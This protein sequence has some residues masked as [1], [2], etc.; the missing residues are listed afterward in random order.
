ML[1]KNKIISL[2]FLVLLGVL[3]LY[4]Y[5]H[6][7][8]IRL[9]NIREDLPYHAEWQVKSLTEEKQNEV[10]LILN[11]PF[12]YQSEGGQS[13]VFSSADNQYV[14][15]LFKYKR[16][17]PAWFV[18]LMPDSAAFQDF[19]ENHVNKRAAKLDRVF[20][21]HKVAYDF[22]QNESGLIFVQLNPSHLSKKITLTDKVGLSHQIDL[23][24]AAFV[25]Q[26]KG[27]MLRHYFAK[28]LNKAQTQV[29]KERI[30]QIFATYVSEYERG[31]YDADHGVMQNFGFIGDQPFH[32]DLGKFKIDNHYK[33]PEVY[34]A[35]LS[36]VA[37]RMR[38]W[39]KKYYPAYY[40]EMRQH[41]ESELSQIFH[42][43]FTFATHEN[44]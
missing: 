36:K 12:T 1:F 38:L 35:D 5:E 27:E 20:M 33:Q 25:V 14:L 44:D 24:E 39:M 13:Y 29:V 4:V 28:L 7:F 43:P 42:K 37:E 40:D 15:K 8:D 26:K 17:R 2:L 22:I 19:K 30:S 10:A 23:G 18:T 9:N 32:L 3:G 41:I 11:Q 31:I 21:G 6:Y 34:Q 16:F